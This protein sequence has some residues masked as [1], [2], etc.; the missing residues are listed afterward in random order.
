MRTTLYRALLASISSFSFSCYFA[1]LS[2]GIAFKQLII[3]SCSFRSCMAAGVLLTFHFFT[4]LIPKL[5]HVDDGTRFERVF[6]K[7]LDTRNRGQ[8]PAFCFDGSV[9]ASCFSVLRFSPA[10]Y[11]PTRAT[12]CTFLTNLY[13]TYF[14]TTW[15]FPQNLQVSFVP[16]N[17]NDH[18]HKHPYLSPSTARSLYD[19]MNGGCQG[20]KG[21]GL[22][23][24]K[25][26]NKASY[27]TVIF[28]SAFCKND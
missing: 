27:C 16:L 6:P 7:M 18:C 17:N 3:L 19:V 21:R 23:R 2:S 22:G 9:Q 20:G 12:I 11:Q 13:N 4:H 10:I 24:K 25:R 28:L 5:S 8:P 14:R 1:F 15:H 26:W